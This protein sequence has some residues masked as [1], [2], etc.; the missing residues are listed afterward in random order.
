VSVTLTTADHTQAAGARLAAA[1]IASDPHDRWL[2]GL[3]GEL[4]A[5]KTTFVS[6]F[7]RELGHA[8]A[9]RSPTYT[10]I[11]PYTLQG[12]DVYHCDLY[13]LTTTR[14]VEDLGLH[15]LLTP[16]A[17][18]LVEWPSR[19]GDRLG[20]WDLISRLEYLAPGDSDGRRLQFV[21]G[22]AQGSALLSAHGLES[23]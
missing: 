21:A 22:S 2:I 12:R 10:F 7:L 3:E 18:V 13:R 5:G 4:G 23:A 16:G 9:V 19:A 8:G 6:G 20:A 14:A 15:E 17:I 11:E 1:I